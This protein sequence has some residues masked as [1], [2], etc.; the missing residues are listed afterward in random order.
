MK[1]YRL[2]LGTAN[3]GAQ[4]GITNSSEFDVSSSQDVINLAVNKGLEIF[5]TAPQYGVA[6]ELLGEC[7]RYE[8]EPKIITKIP[9]V[10]S[11]TYEYVYDSIASSL[12]RL[13]KIKLFG[14]MFH[15]PEIY[16]KKGIREISKKLLESGLVERIGFSAYSLESVISAKDSNEYF[17][18]FQVPENILDGRLVNSKDL[19]ELSYSG[20]LFFVR[21]VFL[22]G[23]LLLDSNK[24]PSRFQKYKNIFEQV[25]QLAQQSSVTKLDL[26]LSYAEKIAWSSGTIVAAASTAQLNEILNFKMTSIE[27]SALNKLP[28]VV[29]DPR[30]WDAIN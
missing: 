24:L 4:Y 2:I 22:Q 13:G 20:N 17:T 1:P 10:A 16:K 7:L 26:C 6:E 12:H 15:D 14:V 11:Y 18:I 27:L 30:L 19:L 21:S 8:I 28:E 23:L 25:E 29:L 9:S 5:D 3:L